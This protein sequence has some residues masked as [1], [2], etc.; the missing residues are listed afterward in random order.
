MEIVSS[1]DEYS[2]D[3]REPNTFG[4]RFG[5][6]HSSYDPAAPRIAHMEQQHEQLAETVDTMQAHLASVLTS[7]A[8]LTQHVTGLEQGLATVVSQQ[9]AATADAA[10]LRG[11]I[12][13]LLGH[14][15]GGAVTLSTPTTPTQAKAELPAEPA[16]GGDTSPVEL[17][18]LIHI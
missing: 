15:T 13:A 12:Q 18:S 3:S 9:Q 16:P 7:Q 2:E 6:H 17:L 1:G 5:H 11:D 10:L 8:E 4:G 14:L